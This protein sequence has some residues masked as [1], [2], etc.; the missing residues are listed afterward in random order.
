MLNRA[1]FHHDPAK[2]PI[3][4][5]GVAD[6]ADADSLRFELRTFVCEGEYEAAINGI[7]DSYLR[8]LDRA[9]QP[10]VW[11]S[12][13]FGS[14]KSH[15]AKMLAA[16]WTDQEL[17]DQ[18]RARSVAQL[19]QETTDKLREL[20]TR[21]KTH[22]P[23][24]V[25]A[26][27]LLGREDDPAVAVLGI[28]LGSVGLPATYHAAA[29]YK[30][31]QDQGILEKVEATLAE[32]GKTLSQLWP[33]MF[34]A[35]DFAEAIAQHYPGLGA[36]SKDVLK[37]LGQ[38]FPRRP[39]LTVT[40]FRDLAQWA[41]RHGN[42]YRLTAVILDEV[43]Q[44]LGDDN[45]KIGQMQVVIES[46]SKEFDGRIIVI[47]T[48]QSAMTMELFGGKLTDRF[49]VKYILKETDVQR[50]VRR[51]VL[52]KEE[53][54]VGAV[55]AKLDE[56]SG[57]I[58][59]HLGGSRIAPKSGDVHAFVP[60]YPLLPARQ[61]FWSAVLRAYDPTE[62][63]GRVR[64][65]L[66]VVYR[67]VLGVLDERLGHVIPGDAIYHEI[68]PVLLQYRQLPESLATRIDEYLASDNPAEKLKGSLLALVHLIHLLPREGEGD[69]GVRATKD[70]LADLL[71][72]DLAAGSGELR[73]RVQ[74][75][76]AELLD[77]AELMEVEGEY[78]LQT[79]ESREW[80]STFGRQRTAL[81]KPEHI[82]G[83]QK[84]RVELLVTDAI[85]KVKP[86]Q[87]AAKLTRNV[88][89]G[90]G[91]GAPGD[92][93]K[94]VQ[95]YVRNEWDEAATSILDDI[96]G[97]GPD[98]A[99]VTVI[100]PRESGAHLR[101]NIVRYLAAAKTIEARGLSTPNEEVAK[102][103]ANFEG[104]RTHADEAIDHILSQEVLANAKVYLDGGDPVSGA[105]L[106]DAVRDAADRA[107]KRLFHRFR[108]ADFP[109]TA[110]KQ[111]L[112]RARKQDD[113]PLKPVGY[114]G[115]ITTH[116]VCH[117]VHAFVSANPAKRGSNIIDHFARAPYGWEDDAVIAA[118]AVLTKDKHLR[119]AG[120][121]G[122]SLEVG[123]LDAASVKTASFAAET[124][125]LSVAERLKLKGAFSSL[126]GIQCSTQELE[127][128][129]QLFV[130]RLIELA[131]EVGGEPPLPAAAAPPKLKALTHESGADLLKSILAADEQLKAEVEEWNQQKQRKAERW[132][133][134]QLLLRLH[135]H[136]DGTQIGA[137]VG[138]QIEA[139]R[140]N[141]SLLGESDPVPKLINALTDVLRPRLTEVHAQCS[142]A[143]ADGLA[144]LEASGSWGGLSD[145]QRRSIASRYQL[146][147]PEPI[148]V[149]TD[150][151]LAATLDQRSLG[152]WRNLL[153]AFEN[154]FSQAA[155]EAAR[156]LEPKVQPVRVPGRLLK[157]EADA[158][159]WLDEVEST[160]VEKLKDGPVQVG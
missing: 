12:G 40:E 6:F 130:G 23:L 48:G 2:N 105:T 66:R 124:V 21:E 26:G 144:R 90:F 22:A 62:T 94:Q 101:E 137:A 37:A 32:K 57:E 138:G 41:L 92:P 77:S 109:G 150:E 44:Y 128:C 55:K 18:S 159:A 121:G 119:A 45:D 9:T 122:V 73:K 70:H 33:N 11:L 82:R 43:Q 102:I 127:G 47:G 98:S 151:E 110:W 145:D 134:W 52:D 76:L 153:D 36:D 136:A 107:A 35:R 28:I 113:K 87:G 49:T 13:F 75:S 89:V 51:V 5:D 106:A 133:R 83:E 155:A 143:F 131:N 78:H 15:V 72:A 158:Q 140:T 8:N 59:R 1:V 104:R 3:A 160:I 152:D 116:P 126:A 7:L 64:G 27:K 31:L 61:R 19:P 141:R 4:N 114:E 125:T 34:V 123:K 65:M 69:T 112:D 154:R 16:L 103:R 39:R 50:V 156:L 97:R 54:A 129:A 117:E 20:S 100:L 24:H 25:A 81:N 10:A 80:E 60:D 14:G 115:D 42:S 68:A 71:V 91:P 53:T 93:G 157:S 74:D 96:R 84:R 88:A 29:A 132:P 79:S 38:Q 67:A 142:K 139:I 56:C 118:L 58:N 135:R 17:H 108:E 147:P 111:V 146:S 85:G 95:V 148:H 120:Q 99:G 86:T 149:G 46:L 63:K 30:W